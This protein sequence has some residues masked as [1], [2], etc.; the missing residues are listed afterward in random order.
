[1]EILGLL[2]INLSQLNERSTEEE[3]WAVIKSLLPDKAPGPDGFTARFLQVAWPI[4][5]PDIM[6]AFDAFWHL[7]TR[8]LHSVNDV[9]LVLLPKSADAASVKDF[10]PIS[11]IHVIG[12]L[13]SKVLANR[14]APRLGKLVR[15]NQS[16]FIKGRAIHDNFKMVQL[17]AKLL[18]ARK[19]PCM[20]LKI[21]IAC[22]FDSVASFLLEVLQHMGFSAR[23]RDWI[24]AL[25]YTAST[26]VL[27]NRTP[28]ERIHH[29]RGLRQGDPL[30]PILFLLVMEVLNALIHKADEWLLLKPLGVNGVMHHASFYAD[31]LVWFVAPEQKDLLMVRSILSLFEGCSGL[32]CNMNKCQLAPIRCAPNQVNMATSIFPGQLVEFPIKYLGIPLAVTKLPRSAL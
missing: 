1:M 15:A 14:L 9:L 16:A 20:L 19:K 25:L 10:R 6:A 30:S 4:I 3:V 7:D 17:S 5:R 22:T 26:K 23:W 11:L 8:N 29:A 18:H 12:K 28:G 21:D 13:V 32:G 31:D 2:T 24:S 27:L